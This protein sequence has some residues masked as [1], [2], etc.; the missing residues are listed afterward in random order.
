M[1]AILSNLSDLK[2]GNSGM[3]ANL[4]II[5]DKDLFSFRRAQRSE[6]PS[7]V[8]NILIRPHFIFSSSSFLY[9][10]F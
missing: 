2:D 1:I 3:G 6:T 4:K 5:T 8:S 10:K 7:D 9:K